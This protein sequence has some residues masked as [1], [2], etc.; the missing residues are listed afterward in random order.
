MHD[1]DKRQPAPFAGNPNV[2]REVVRETNRITRE[3]EKHGLE[4]R[5][6]Y[7]LAPALGGSVVNK[8]GGQKTVAQAAPFGP[9]AE[10][11]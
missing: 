10:M 7:N 6:R 4:P 8:P 2:N 1:A 5:P 3:L 9:V 11:R